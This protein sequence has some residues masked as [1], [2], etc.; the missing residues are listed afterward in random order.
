MWR[1]MLDRCGAGWSE[2]L[3]EHHR[4]ISFGGRTWVE[5][6]KGAGTGGRDY[7]V[8]AWQ[9]RRMLKHLAI[10]LDCARREIP[11]L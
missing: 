5:F 6:P 8:H 10:D 4:W 1:R 3:N 9:V 2:R 11:A 7:E